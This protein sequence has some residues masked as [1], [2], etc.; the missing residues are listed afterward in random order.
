MVGERANQNKGGL[1][2]IEFIYTITTE[3]RFGLTMW[4]LNYKG[5]KI[6]SFIS[7]TECIKTMRNLLQQSQERKRFNKVG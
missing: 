4:I 3:K 6:D 2:M 1:I 5:S 7:H